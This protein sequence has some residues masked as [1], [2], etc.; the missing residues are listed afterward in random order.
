MNQV[1]DGKIALVELKAFFRNYGAH[2]NV[3][4]EMVE[5]IFEK[6]DKN[7]DGSLTFDEAC[8]E[9]ADF[10]RSIREDLHGR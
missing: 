2:T 5:N 10:I 4:D 8:Y 6:F 7:N 3:T 1:S 9:F